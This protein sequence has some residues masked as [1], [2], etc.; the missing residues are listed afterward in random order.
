MSN[1]HIWQPIKAFKNAC[2]SGADTTGM[3]LRKLFICEDVKQSG[4]DSERTLDFTIS[5]GQIDRDGDTIAV[6]GWKLAPFRKNPVVLWAHNSSMPP[7]AKAKKVRVEDGKLKSS[8]VFVP[9]DLSDHDHIKFSGM[10]FDMFKQKFMNAVSVGFKPEEFSINEG[11]GGFL[12]TDF[13][14]QELLEFSP[15]PVPSNPGA[16]VEARAAGI[17]TS[18]MIAW[19]EKTLDE[20]GTAGGLWLS[21]STLERLALELNGNPTSVSGTPAKGGDPTVV[22]GTP[23][24]DDKALVGSGDV[25][26]VVGTGAGDGDSPA[27]AS[28]DPVTLA[29]T[30]TDDGISLEAS[31]AA[32]EKAEAEMLD[33]LLEG[34][35][36]LSKRGRVLSTSNER[37]LR[38]AAKL[39][40]AVLSQLKDSDDDD[41]DDDDKTGKTGN[42]KGD[43]IDL[44][45]DDL[46]EVIQ[47][48]RSE[49]SERFRK[50]TGSLD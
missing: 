42:L 21:K 29:P 18:P 3:S 45:E 12:P 27:P 37:K 6:D 1:K 28:T 46:A 14:K 50:A 35:S 31:Y 2:K 20:F 22:S 8:A 40:E 38:D 44:S 34:V 36:A 49:V 33:L 43:E 17:D 23:A 48:V 25:D 4:S 39:L 32:T 19:A 24:K 5:T 11:R 7:I 41:D 15:V 10:I 30:A 16:L 26:G 9:P 47:M 13:I